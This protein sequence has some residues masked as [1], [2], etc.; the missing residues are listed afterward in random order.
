MAWF[1]NFRLWAVIILSVFMGGCAGKGL[2]LS[3]AGAAG[4]KDGSF[5]SERAEKFV[6]QL[7]NG[8]YSAAA[9]SLDAQMAKSLNADAL[10]QAWNGAIEQAGAF[11]AI[12]KTDNLTQDGYYIC[13]VTSRHENKNVVSRVVFSEDG[14]ILGLFFS[15]TENS[16]D[17]AAVQ[18][19]KPKGFTEIPVVVGEGTEFPLNGI[20][21]LPDGSGKF[22]AVVLV[23]GSGQSDMNE[24]IYGIS[25]FKDIA[26]YLSARGIAVLRYDKRT[27]AH[28]AEF[29]AKYGDEYTVWDETID[30]AVKAKAVLDAN[31]HI[32]AERI[33]VLGHSLGGM[34]APRLTDEG[35]FSGA[36][37][38]AGSPRSLLD[39]IYDQNMH[40]I[41]LMEV[42]DEEKTALIAQVNAARETCFGLP[43][44]YFREMDA[45]PVKDYLESTNKPFL[46]MQ[47]G[48][49]F[50]V[51][52]DA[53]FEIYKKI[54]DGR[55]NI[56][57]KLYPNLNHLFT[58][59]TME[60]PTTDDY[61]AG[62]HVDTAPLTDIAEWIN[63]PAAQRNKVTA[64]PQNAGADLTD[65]NN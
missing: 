10:E 19:E 30:D 39:I 4:E 57:L 16:G 60:T 65:I 43:A 46:I 41:D 40:S 26:D 47:G 27:K 1:K 17:S 32:D 31:E 15:Y 50:Q 33:F 6:K 62:S 29:A 24:T 48:K 28:S 58:V 63:A 49:D 7:V 38:M 64:P 35:G 18:T 3:T 36:V 54:A 42:D 8:E 21:S 2:D 45:H 52:A 23:H 11:S 34:L 14:L 55:D 25:V 22:P 9:E 20:L 12:V 13:L 37:I 5:Y 51:Y 44:N 59:S 61:A 56:E 53:D